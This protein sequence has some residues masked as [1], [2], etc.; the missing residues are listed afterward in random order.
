M[1]VPRTPSTSPLYAKDFQLA[2]SREEPTEEFC[3]TDRGMRVVSP[4]DSVLAGERGPT[5]LEDFHLREDHALR[6]RAYP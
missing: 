4:D 1:P 6:S 2:G 5:L 3:T